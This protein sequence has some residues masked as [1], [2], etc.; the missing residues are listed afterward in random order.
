MKNYVK[1]VK[2][3]QGEW[4]WGLILLGALSAV[5]VAIHVSQKYNM[6]DIG[7]ISVVIAGTMAFILSLWIVL[8]E[9]YR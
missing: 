7:D 4:N 6:Y 1:H 8:D 2:K 5:S 9:R 3:K